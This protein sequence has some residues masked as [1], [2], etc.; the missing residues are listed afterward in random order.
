[1]LVGTL[2]AGKEADMIVV[3]GDPSKDVRALWNVREVFLA[4]KRVERGSD[5]SLL[6]FHQ[7][8]PS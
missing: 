8:P 7:S 1:K 4:G 3:D 5:E 2:E 6:S